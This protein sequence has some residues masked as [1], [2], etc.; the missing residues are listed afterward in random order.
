M[1]ESQLYRCPSRLVASSTLPDRGS[2]G[3]LIRVADSNEPQATKQRA[4]ARRVPEADVVLDDAGRRTY[5][6]CYR[7]GYISG[8]QE[9]ILVTQWFYLDR[10]L[11][12][13]D[14]LGIGA[15]GVSAD[16]RG[17]CLARYWWW[18]ELFAVTRAWLDLNLLHP[19]PVLGEELPI[20]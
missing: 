20:F 11:C 2:A 8:V 10:A 9:A 19:T 17:Y 16:R 12:T 6:T 15:V 1:T 5:D 4:A 18:R 14:R 3:K 13:C 7:A